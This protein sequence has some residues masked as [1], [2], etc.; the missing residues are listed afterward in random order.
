MDKYQDLLGVNPTW[1]PEVNP[2]EQDCTELEPGTVTL[3]SL[4]DLLESGISLAPHPVL[5]KSLAKLQ[6][7]LET[8]E[9]IEDKASNSLQ[10]K[11]KLALSSVEVIVREVDLLPTY[12]PSVMA[13]KDSLRKAKEWMSKFD[14]LQ[15]VEFSPYLETLETLL[16]KAKPIAIKLEPLEQLE[17]QVGAGHAW[18]ERTART[19]LRKNSYYTLVEVLSP[20]LDILGRVRYTFFVGKVSRLLSVGKVSRFLSVGKPSRLLSVSFQL[21]E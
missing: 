15:K 14:A 12:L 4:R 8:S 19:F 21:F 20:K 16:A 7:L 5:E 18:R 10:S 13:L 11:T 2:L 17:G 6:G 1:D 9:K 3:D